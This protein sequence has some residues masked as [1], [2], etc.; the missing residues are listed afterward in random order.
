MGEVV[1]EV[2]RDRREGTRREHCESGGARGNPMGA[3]SRRVPLPIYS[4]LHK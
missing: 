4:A 2:V 1:E 3:L